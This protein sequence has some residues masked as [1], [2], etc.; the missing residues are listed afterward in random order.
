[1]LKGG[2]SHLSPLL[3]SQLNV[4]STTE[5]WIW[6]QVQAGEIADLNDRCDTPPLSIYQNKDPQWQEPC[7]RV[8]PKLLRT[9]LTQPDLADKS[10]HGVRI[11][12]ALINGDLDLQDAHVRTAEVWLDHS[13]INGAAVLV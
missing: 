10:P 7:R 2:V 1:M 9:L 5:G 13:W 6:Q 8:D 3:Q 12:G 11:S 4:S